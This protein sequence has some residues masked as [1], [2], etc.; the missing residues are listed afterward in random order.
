MGIVSLIKENKA[1]N[2]ISLEPVPLPDGAHLTSFYLSEQGMAMKPRYMLK[3]KEDGVYM[4]VTN[5][6]ASDWRMTEGLD[7]FDS[8]DR[9]LFI[10]EVKD[11]EHAVSVR[12]DDDSVVRKLEAIIVETGCI[13]WDGYDV[14]KSMKGVLDA[15]DSYELY[16]E[17]SD[18]TTVTV[19]GYN[20]H[21]Q[22]WRE[23]ISAVSEVFKTNCSYDK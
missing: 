11:C 7:N 17:F 22:K 23:L 3:E 16:M 2:K 6:E 18:K 13:S 19:N 1:K 5:L 12:L 9:F 20:S 4:K 10:D 15:G 21:P 8:G 14:H